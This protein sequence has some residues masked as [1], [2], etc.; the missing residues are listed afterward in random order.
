[1]S[2]DGPYPCPC[3]DC[4]NAWLRQSIIQQLEEERNI[5]QHRLEEAERALRTASGVI[6]ILGRNNP[7]TGIDDVLAQIDAAL[8]GE[9][10]NTGSFTIKVNGKQDEVERVIET[11]RQT[12][13]KVFLVKPEAK[14]ESQD[15]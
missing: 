1:M 3:N 6:K 7:S 11:L 12:S 8:S 14:K 13:I 10:K 4:D 9:P 5:L 15:G 2:D